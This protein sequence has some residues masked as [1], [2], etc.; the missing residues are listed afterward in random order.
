MSLSIEFHY[1]VISDPSWQVQKEVRH[2][3]WVTVFYC[4]SENG[5]MECLHKNIE[6]HL[7]FSKM[8]PDEKARAILR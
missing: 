5:A 2:G 3:E 7:E 1:R 4:S 8:S 6:R